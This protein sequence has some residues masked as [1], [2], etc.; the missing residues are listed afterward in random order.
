[1]PDVLQLPAGKERCGR[2]DQVENRETAEE[3][4]PAAQGKGS[5]NARNTRQRYP[6]AHERERR[7][8]VA[9]KEPM[10][11]KPALLTR[12]ALAEI[13]AALNAAD[14][15]P[16]R[17]EK[18]GQMV[19]G[20]SVGGCTLTP[21]DYRVADV[22]GWG[23]L[24]YRGSERYGPEA[25][26]LQDANGEL[27]ARGP[28][29]IQSLLAHIDAL[30]SLPPVEP[31]EAMVEAGARAICIELD[32][33]P[34]ATTKCHATWRGWHQ[35]IGSARAALKAALALAKPQEHNASEGNG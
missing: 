16:W 14:G 22:R 8:M 35:Y 32:E 29:I 23:H 4:D 20:H 12:E 26:A 1:M 27:L 17:Y 13:R 19:F 7:E 24:Q 10:T 11:H 21:S 5:P 28:Q 31:T 34:D 3:D 9:R 6:Q 25:Q 2:G 15:W 33:E 30:E 18:R